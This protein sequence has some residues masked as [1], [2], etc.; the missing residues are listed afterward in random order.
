MTQITNPA[1]AIRTS[2]TREPGGECVSAVDIFGGT[3]GFDPVVRD[4]LYQWHEARDAVCCDPFG[5]FC[6]PSVTYARS[7]ARE[8][9]AL[10]A[11]EAEQRHAAH[12]RGDG[13]ECLTEPH[14]AGR[15]R[16]E[17]CHSRYMTRLL[18]GQPK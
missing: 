7:C 1:L 15:T 12:Q 18:A 2:A 5:P 16:C 14:S 8:R 9:D 3:A 10:V 4:A 6:A 11:L 13:V 17:S